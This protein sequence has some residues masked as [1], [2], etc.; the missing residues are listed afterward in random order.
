MPTT[1]LYYKMIN[2]PQRH[3]QDVMSILE[4]TKNPWKVSNTWLICLNIF[5]D[6]Y[7][8]ISNVCQFYSEGKVAYLKAK[9]NFQG[10]AKFGLKTDNKQL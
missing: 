5:A 1:D 6:A 4:K 7:L 10:L 3:V 2:P 8:N 9:V